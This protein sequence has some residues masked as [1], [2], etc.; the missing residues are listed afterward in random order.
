MRERALET[1]EPSCMPRP[2]R[3]FFIPEA[4]GPL[5]AAGHVTA[6][7]PSRV[8]RQGPKPRG[9]WQRRSSPE[10]RGRV[11]SYGARDSVR[12]LPSR[13]AGSRA[14]GHVTASEPSRARRRSLELRSTWQHRNPPEQGGRVRS[15]WA[16]GS[17]PYSLSWTQGCMRGYPVC[18]VHTDFKASLGRRQSNA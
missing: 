12:A 5:R 4:H 7:E 9:T 18:R 16:C 6:S 13:E 2:A 10:Q 8:G 1:R 17:T 3:P 11:R 15:Y 14:A